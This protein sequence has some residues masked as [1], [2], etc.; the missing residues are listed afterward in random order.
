[1]QVIRARSA[2][3][4][5][6][7]SLALRRLDQEVEASGGTGPAEEEGSSPVGPE[8][9]LI[10][11][12]PIIHNPLVMQEYIEKGVV[13]ANDPQGIGPGDRVVIR[14]H[15][16]PRDVE[17]RIRNSG[18]TIIDATCP[19][20]KKA[21]VAIGREHS[22]GGDLLLF[23]EKE[24]PEVRGLLSYAGNHALVF[25]DLQELAGFE[26]APGR[27]WF[28][29]AQTTQ[30]RSVFLQA[31][32][33]LEARLGR[34]VPTLCT[35]CDAT[36]DRQQEVIDLSGRVQAMVVVGGLNSGNTRRLAEVARANGMPTIHVER[37]ED[38]TPELAAA[39]F[40]GVSVIGLTA[41]ASTPEKHIDAMQAYLERL[42][43]L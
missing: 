5:L 14:A 16:I 4:C 18:A 26:L 24:H 35:I 42:R 41:G 19:K 40:A 20:V 25:G 32:E 3:F 10:T 6:G 38:I 22:K 9:R 21:Q 28:L 23:G 43:P 30:D 36:R 34:S 13:C 2:G 27:A 37:A 7:V 17:A 1:M 31:R 12:G 33:Y 8:S 39:T 15:G 11:L 29:A